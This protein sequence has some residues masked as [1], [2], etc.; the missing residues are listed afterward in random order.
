MYGVGQRGG[1]SLER[2]A[3]VL[4][5]DPQNPTARFL[6]QARFPREIVGDVMI[7]MNNGALA[8]DRRP[9]DLPE[10]SLNVWD[11]DAGSRLAF[12]RGLL[13]WAIDGGIVGAMQNVAQGVFQLFGRAFRRRTM[14]EVRSDERPD[15]DADGGY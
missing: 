1:N 6:Q 15:D 11:Q 12:Q 4:L 2:V 10:N 13:D 3:Q 9:V 8:P 7:L 14:S 5:V